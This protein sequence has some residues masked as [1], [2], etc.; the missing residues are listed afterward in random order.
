MVAA[1]SIVAVRGWELTC[2]ALWLAGIWVLRKYGRTP[3]LVGMYLGSTVAAGLWDWILGSSWFFRLRFDHRFFTLYSLAGRGEPLWAPLS[4]GFFFGIT[5]ILAVRFG[6]QLDGAFGRWH[7]VVIPILLGLADIVIEG[8]TTT[9]LDLYAFQYRKAWLAFGVPYTNVLFVAVTEVFLIYLGRGLS[10]LFGTRE[11]QAS[12]LEDR[13]FAT[14]AGTGRGPA[15]ATLVET[16]VL[17]TGRAPLS[18]ALPFWVGLLV[19]AGAI[20]AGAVA[21][22]VVLNALIK[23]W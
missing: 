1:T 19:P 4:Y 23:P 16:Q 12:L 11:A 17:T 7:L 2:L 18:G 21:T 5:T 15:T 22:T 13:S 3:L 20:F 8:I 6:P 14:W 9:A 10:G